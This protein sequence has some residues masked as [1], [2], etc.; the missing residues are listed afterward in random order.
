MS[1]KANVITGALVTRKTRFAVVSMW[2]IF[3]Y[4]GFLNQTENGE[5]NLV[6]Y[7]YDI[8]KELWCEVIMSVDIAAK[9]LDM[10]NILRKAAE[11]TVLKETPKI[12]RAF[13]TKDKKG[14][15]T[16]TTDGINITAMYSFEH[17]LDLKKLS[18]NNIHEMAR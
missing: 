14:H 7:S 16:L 10:T 1:Q 5:A 3:C 9:K 4:G 15:A 17:I 12:K 13:I 2:E 18:C 8:E 11:K 6:G